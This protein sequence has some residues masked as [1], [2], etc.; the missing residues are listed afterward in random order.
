[1]FTRDIIKINKRLGG[2][3]LNISS[4]EF[5]EE[6]E[7]DNK[8]S[9]KKS[10]IWVR[11]IIIDHPFTDFNKRTALV[12]VANFIKIENQIRVA[13]A[14]VKIAKKN[15]TDLDKI[16]EMIKNANRREN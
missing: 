16:V 15:I 4:L 3:L 1:M 5:A 2:S 10:A 14:L 7:K 12:V 11:A 8:G 9:Y 6:L 13:E